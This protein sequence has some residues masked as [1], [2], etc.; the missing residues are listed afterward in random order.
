MPAHIIIDSH[1]AGLRPLLY[2]PNVLSACGQYN[3]ISGG[4]AGC[5]GLICNGNRYLL[6]YKVLLCMHPLLV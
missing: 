6:G 4:I 3:I 5:F 1:I 2:Y